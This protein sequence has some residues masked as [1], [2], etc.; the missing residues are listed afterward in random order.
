VGPRVAPPCL[1][2]INPQYQ[3]PSQNKGLRKQ[4]CCSTASKT[5]ALAEGGVMRRDFFRKRFSVLLAAVL[6]TVGCSTH[7]IVQA[8]TGRFELQSGGFNQFS[9]EQDIQ[10]GRQAASEV[11]RTMPLL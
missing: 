2:H 5:I 3:A 8:P 7:N 4:T 10:V 11:N 6:G 9:P 1:K